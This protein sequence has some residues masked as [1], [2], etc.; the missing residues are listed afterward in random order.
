MKRAPGEHRMNEDAGLLREIQATELLLASVAAGQATEP[1]P[2]K[3]R[4]R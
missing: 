3:R 4:L 2:A 1:L